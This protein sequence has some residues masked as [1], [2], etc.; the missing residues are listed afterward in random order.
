MN[1]K[2]ATKPQTKIQTPKEDRFFKQH[3][4]ELALMQSVGHVSGVDLKHA[5]EIYQWLIKDL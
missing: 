4:R 5:E 1:A 3:M 2:K